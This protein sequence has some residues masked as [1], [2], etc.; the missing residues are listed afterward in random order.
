MV[1]FSNLSTP[2]PQ[3]TLVS[4]EWDFGDGQFSTED[5]PEHDFNYVGTYSVELTVTDEIGCTDVH[6][7]EVVAVE[8][9]FIWIPTAF[10]PNGDGEND[11]YKPILHNVTKSGFELFIYD[12]WGKLVYQSEDIHSGWNGIRQDNGL[13]AESASYSFVMRFISHRDIE[14]KTGL[15]VLLK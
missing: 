2:N 13:S 11:I 15:F 6:S 5:E 12:R 10:T 8:D 9:Y 14:E 3:T 1:Q 7:S 4:S